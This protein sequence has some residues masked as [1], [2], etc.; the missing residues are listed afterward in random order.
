MRER[1]FFLL[2]S[3]GWMVFFLVSASLY[4][5]PRR[6]VRK[7]IL[8][9]RNELNLSDNQVEKAKKYLS[10][11]EKECQ[12]LRT[13]LRSLNQEIR[14]LLEKEADIKEIE[15]KIRESFEIRADLVIAEIKTGRK[16][17]K[18]LT[19]EQF[20]KWKEIRTKET[21]SKLKGRRTE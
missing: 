4:A 6:I 12:E 1:R 16:I 15:D 2:L 13:K 9:Y 8:D 19:P 5:Q 21:K 3:V 18:T 17:N 20:A 10:S 11:F 7:T 14:S